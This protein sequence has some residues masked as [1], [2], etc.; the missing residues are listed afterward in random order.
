M[1]LQTISHATHVLKCHNVNDRFCIVSHLIRARWNFEDGG[2]DSYECYE[3]AFI[4][5]EIANP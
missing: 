2:E 1:Q 5:K 4:N 3:M